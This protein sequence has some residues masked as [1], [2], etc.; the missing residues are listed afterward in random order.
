MNQNISDQSSKD[1]QNIIYHYCSMNSFFKIIES[2]KLW[3]S[4]SKFMNDK[5]E[6]IWVHT[7]VEQTLEKLRADFSEEQIEAFRKKY[8]QIDSD[9][10]FVCCFSYSGDRLSQWRAYSD[11]AKGVAIGFSLDKLGLKNKSYGAKFDIYEGGSVD[12]ESL[13]YENVV[14]DNENQLKIVKNIV[15]YAL[16]S[17]ETIHHMLTLHTTSTLYKHTSFSEE[18]EIRMTYSPQL[19][20][21]NILGKK[22]F[23][24]SNGRIIPYYEFDFRDKMQMLTEIIIGPKSEMTESELKSFLSAY[25][26]SHVRVRKSESSYR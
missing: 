6:T 14:Y 8:R 22:Q 25:G 16:K 24:E 4:D 13:A 11:D 17:P 1:S 10:R 5:Y 15:L 7:L 3:L 19:D 26:F 20:D 12:T 2:K 23:R 18:N 9:Q 21:N